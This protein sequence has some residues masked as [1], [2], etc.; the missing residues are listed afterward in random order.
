VFY[1]KSK[2]VGSIGKPDAAFVEVVQFVFQ[3]GS[4]EH[5]APLLDAMIDIMEM[6]ISTEALALVSNPIL[7]YFWETCSI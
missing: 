6:N 3:Q 1:L 4:C 2:I 7:T 5:V